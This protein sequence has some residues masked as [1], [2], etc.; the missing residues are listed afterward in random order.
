MK[1]L[2]LMWMITKSNGEPFTL[3]E[4][5][6]KFKQYISENNMACPRIETFYMYG[7]F[8]K[9]NLDITQELP[10]YLADRKIMNYN[11]DF[12]DENL[13]DC[14]LIILMYE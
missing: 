1:G 4:W 10:E 8:G 9:P 3:G 7:E 5:Y 11:Y 6:H 14:F 12:T 13:E 2:I